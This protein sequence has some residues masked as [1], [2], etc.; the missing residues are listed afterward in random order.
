MKTYSFKDVTGVF[1]HPLAG[2]F[3]FAGQV[4]AKSIAIA[5]AGEKTV[6]DVAADGE[7][8]VSYIAG[9]NGT[10][11]IVC[12]Q[13]S[14]LHIFLL[15]W[16]NLVKTAADAGDLSDFA[17]ASISLRCLLDGSSHY[18][19]GISLPKL[20]DKAYSAQGQDVSWPL[21]AAHIYNE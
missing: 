6:Q 3:I 15:N 18:I 17:T 14:V 9:E 7:V 19:I 8:M 11:T 2:E 4:G 13:T 21:P 10:V 16:Y 12:Q 1:S 20:G 5:M